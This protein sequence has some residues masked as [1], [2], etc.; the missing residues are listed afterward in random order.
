MNTNAA[1]EPL[2][3]TERQGRIG[4]VKL[5]RPEAR[6]AMSAGLTDAIASALEEFEADDELW[7]TVIT[8]TGESAFCAGQ[9]LKAVAP[10][11]TERGGWGGI[12]SREFVKPVIAAVNGFAL[13][14]GMEICLACDLVV[15]D[16]HAEFGLPEVKRGLFAG[17][18]GL[19]RLPRRIPPALA[20][21]LI[22]TGRTISASRALEL[23]LINRVVPRGQ[24]LAG[25]L[26]LAEEICQAAPLSVRYSKYVARA[27]FSA[28]EDD[29]VR[30]PRGKEL[31]RALVA[32]DDVLE[33]P[34]AFTERRAPQWKGR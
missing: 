13:G 12:T 30:S 7:V 21:E 4:I 5:N 27:A 26:E 11:T 20:M 14:G 8:A 33:G 9:D 15:A 2:V 17:A 31:R 3:L 28:N 32:S 18:G 10:L 24:C 23:G 19:Q 34:R 29:A 6:H 22:L 16:E 25:A 1:G